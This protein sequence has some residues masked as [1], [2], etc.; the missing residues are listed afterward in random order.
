MLFHRKPSRGG[1]RQK[2]HAAPGRS[3]TGFG[4]RGSAG[5][6]GPRT[7]ERTGGTAVLMLPCLGLPPFHEP[8][9]LLS[10]LIPTAALPM[11]LHALARECG[12]F[13]FLTLE[14][15]AVMIYVHLADRET[16]SQRAWC[17]SPSSHVPHG[18]VVPGLCDST[19]PWKMSKIC[20]DFPQPNSS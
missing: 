20:S 16:E 7:R 14:K 6:A 5:P 1:E 11:L 8:S 13:C 4:V 17:S 18:P 12:T 15:E 2:E 19:D 9:Y 10:H 3:F